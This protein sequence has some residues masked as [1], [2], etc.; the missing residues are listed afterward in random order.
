MDELARYAGELGL[1]LTPGQLDQFA[2]YEALLLEWNERISLTAIR[3]PRGVRIR[4]FL[5]S[6][7][8]AIA[9]GPLDGQ[10]MIDVGTGAGFPGLPLKILYPDL[11]LTLVDSVVKKARFLEEVIGEL[12]LSDVDVVIE[13]AEVLGRDAAFRERYDWAVARA[14]AE[15]RVLAELLLPLCRT[16]GSALAQKGESALTETAVAASAV[17]TLGG[18]E[19]RLLA[20]RLLETEQTHYLVVIPKIHPTDSR[21]PRRPGIPAKRPL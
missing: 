8:C 9:T 14:V 19:P 1:S 6:L 3:N 12:G 11:K 2:T 16:G 20:V 7:T 10:S 5:D 18:G 17:V 13:R 15:L 4:H 21:Y